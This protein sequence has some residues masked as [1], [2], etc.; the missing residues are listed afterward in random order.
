MEGRL[1]AGEPLPSK[2]LWL[3]KGTKV[4]EA[5]CIIHMEAA[6]RLRAEAAGLRDEHVKPT[7][8]CLKYILGFLK[9]AVKRCGR[10]HFSGGQFS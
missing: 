6:K 2:S 8:N 9:V 4:A 3:Y 1:R 10:E 7:V 5:N